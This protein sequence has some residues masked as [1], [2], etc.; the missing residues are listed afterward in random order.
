M[1]CLGFPSSR[2]TPL[3]AEVVGVYALDGHPKRSGHPNLLDGDVP[4]L[5]AYRGFKRDDNGLGL[6]LNEHEGPGCVVLCSTGD[7]V[8]PSLLFSGQ[9]KRDAVVHGLAVELH[10]LRRPDDEEWVYTPI[11]LP[12]FV[13]RGDTPASFFGEVG[14]NQS[15]G[16]V[17]GS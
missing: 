11:P 2:G 6:L 8:A 16:V 17:H 3:D 9:L 7:E 12:A 14:M 10:V 4:A 15:M 5:G 13:Q 1:H